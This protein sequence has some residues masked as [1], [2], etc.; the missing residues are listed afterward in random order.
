MA[1]D[2]FNNILIILITC[3]IISALCH[4]LKLPVIIGYIVVG[5]LV[6]PSG[7]GL[8][9]GSSIIS[10]LAEFGIVF[11]MFMVGLEFS[12]TH[13]LRLKKDVFFYGGLQVALTIVIT[14]GLGLI[15][16]MTPIQSLVVGP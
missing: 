14:L 3:I 13:L 1:H 16:Q 15:L 8:I 4:R 7:I 9:S 5:I 2:L 10:L 11:L 6:G 12:L